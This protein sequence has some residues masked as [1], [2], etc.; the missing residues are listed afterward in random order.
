MTG[1]GAGL[2]WGSALMR[3]TQGLEAPPSKP[4]TPGQRPH[5]ETTEAQ[6]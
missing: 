6:A 2:T 5:A 4:A 1:M 3:W